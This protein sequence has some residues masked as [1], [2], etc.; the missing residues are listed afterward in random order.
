MARPVV[1]LPQPDSPTSPSVSP[2]TM[3]RLTSVTACTVAAPTGELDD[4]VL[5][6]Q[7]RLVRGP[8][9]RRAAA[10]HRLGHHL[11]GQGERLG[12]GLA[13]GHVALERSL[14][15]GVPTGNQQRYW[16]PAEGPS[17]SGG[18]SSM[19]RSCT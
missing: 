6:A 2:W 19:Q 9:V 18:S 12:G 10:G 3:S 15:S 14:P 8:E 7:Q 4:E 11:A 1:D 17:V 16:W 13:G 5:D